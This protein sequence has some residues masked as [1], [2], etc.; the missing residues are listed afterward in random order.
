MAG[1]DHTISIVGSVKNLVLDLVAAIKAKNF[2][3]SS[4]IKLAGDI[5]A[6]AKDVVAIWPELKDIDKNEFSA[7]MSALFAA[8]EEIYKTV[9]LGT[10]F[11]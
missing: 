2:G 5:Y 8:G 10:K 4:M 9:V 11:A 7:L 6:V 3:F 1:I